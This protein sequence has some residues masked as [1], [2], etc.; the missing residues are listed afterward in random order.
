MPVPGLPTFAM[1][2]EKKNLTSPSFR[3]N[4]IRPIKWFFHWQIIFQGYHLT[5]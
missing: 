1:R 3:S 4:V 5:I 2:N